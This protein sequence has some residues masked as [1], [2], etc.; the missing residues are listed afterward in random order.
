MSK[1]VKLAAMRESRDIE[2][3]LHWALVKQGLGLDLMDS[4]SVGPS[5]GG[6]TLGTKIDGGG[7]GNDGKWVHADAEVVARQLQLMS[8][9][10]RTSLAAALVVRH[11]M[12]GT[13][14]D[15]G[16]EIGGYRLMRKGNGKAIRR[17]ADQR[18]GAGLLG[19]HWEWVGPS[20]DEVE[21]AM[22]EYA[23]WHAALV[24]LREMI[25]PAMERYVASGPAAPASPWDEERAAAPTILYPTGAS[26]V[27]A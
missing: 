11:G 2:W 7:A 19:F 3:V 10:G 25:N 13:R 24:D 1:V 20:V 27:D 18:K 16:S 22:L 15:W 12:A 21:K 14:P 23:A 4:R 17:Y 8:R 9:D 6:S 5:S 26:P